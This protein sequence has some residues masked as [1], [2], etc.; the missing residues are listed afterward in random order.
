MSRALIFAAAALLGL[1]ALQAEAL[2]PSNEGV[3]S[4]CVYSTCTDDEC[5]ARGLECCPKPCGGTWCVEGK[6]VDS[7]SEPTECPQVPPPE[8]GCQGTPGSITCS[9]VRCPGVPCCMDG[10]GKPYCLNPP[11]GTLPFY[12]LLGRCRR[13]HCPCP[14]PQCIRGR[15]S[16]VTAAD[17][18]VATVPARSWG[19]T[20]C[21][22]PCGNPFCME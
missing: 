21:H 4:D 6:C 10:C 18:S 9:N 5:A 15:A 19:K 2:C 11:D 13:P 1:L 22:G 7:R 8:G 14:I 3:G 20:C 16:G 12:S 17:D